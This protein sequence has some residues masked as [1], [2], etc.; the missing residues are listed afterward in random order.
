MERWNIET[1]E[2]IQH[3]ATGRLWVCVGLNVFEPYL[4]P[5]QAITVPPPLELK[6]PTWP[7]E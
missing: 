6:P 2:V 4:A 1:G 3:P 5:A 7:Q